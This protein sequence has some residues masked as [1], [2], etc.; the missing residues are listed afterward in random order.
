M[1]D[2]YLTLAGREI[3]NL[4]RVSA[5]AQSQGLGWFKGC[6]PCNN[7]A[8]FLHGGCYVSPKDDPAPWFREG[9][10]ESYKYLGAAMLKGEGFV[11]SQRRSTLVDGLH[12]SWMT[13]TS[14]A[15]RE[16]VVRLLLVATDFD[17]LDY[18]IGWLNTI[19]ESEQTPTSTECLGTTLR[20][21]TACPS[22]CS[23]HQG[24]GDCEPGRCDAFRLAMWWEQCRVM[25][26]AKLLR[27]QRMPSGGVFGE[28]EMVIGSGSGKMYGI[29]DG[30]YP[31]GSLP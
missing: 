28:V 16:M 15:G 19:P 14:S 4:P 13:R 12:T 29:A 11:D 20:A 26:G 3:V 8:Q 23:N 31:V 2:G 24:V 7:L 17:G 9:Y 5:Y 6:S 21:F 18:G 1:Y 27:Q 22:P 30:Y 25:D 10:I